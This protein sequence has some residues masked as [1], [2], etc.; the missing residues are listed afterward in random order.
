MVTSDCDKVGLALEEDRCSYNMEEYLGVQLLTMNRQRPGYRGWPS[1]NLLF[2]SRTCEP[3][4]D[5]WTLL[6]GIDVTPVRTRSR[7]LAI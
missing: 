6:L 5:G 2:F 3:L 7:A 1:V 4:S